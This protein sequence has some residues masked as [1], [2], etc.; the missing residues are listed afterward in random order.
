MSGLSLHRAALATGAQ[1]VREDRFPKDLRVVTDTRAIEPGDTFLALR[2][3]RFDGHA[4]VAEALDRGAA[5]V[6][7]DDPKA[8]VEG[9]PALLVADT[10][11]AYM[12][13]A[14]AV[15]DQFRGQVIAITGSAGKTTTKHLLTQLLEAHYGPS[16]VLATPLNENNEIGVSKLLLRARSDHRVLVIEMGAR[17]EGEIAEL[18]QI[19]RP[20]IGVLTNIGEAHMEIFGSREQL[21]RT[22]WGL[23]SQGAQAVLNARDSE[24]VLR[25]AALHTPPLWFG[26]GEPVVPGVWVRSARSIVLTIG[27]RPETYA[28]DSR[29]PG[30]H[31]RANL[32]G[33]IA[34]ALL[35]GISIA[36]LVETIPSLTLPPGR[37]ESVGM[38]GGARLI[39]DAYNANL[40]GML[41]ALDAFA[42]ETAERH[43]AVLASMAELG[44]Q[45]PAMHERVGAHAAVTNIDSLLVG[46]EFASSLAAGAIAAGF[47]RDRIIPF[48]DN[49]EA[50]EW[51]RAHVGPRDAVLLKGS[52]K[53]KMEEIVSALRVPASELA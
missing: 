43:V 5:A 21:A 7:L 4:F 9:V 8:L 16:C 42:G 32:A 46:G 17:H 3:E 35:L 28:I 50:V 13:L 23:F 19:A 14:G 30:T 33:A 18:T 26:A 27:E 49:E 24:S 29:L 44:S 52:R 37:Y 47:P 36:T 6:V 34:A 22:K 2:G 12:D 38:I 53:Y 10:K 45:A 1:V 51:L 39:Y 48:A 41:A 11:R 31:N 15:R 25:G 40:S 20:H